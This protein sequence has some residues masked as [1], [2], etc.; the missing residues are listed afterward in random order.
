MPNE[1]QFLDE[2]LLG[3]NDAILVCRLLGQISQ[4]WDDLIDQ[5]RHVP[6]KAINEAFTAAVIRL[7]ALPFYREH[8][9]EL[10]PLLRQCFIDWM[11][12]NQ[13]ERTKSHHDRSMAFVLRDSLVSVVVHCAFL[14]G[15]HEHAIAVAPRIRRFFH[16]ETLETYIGG[17]S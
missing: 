14:V 2:V 6:P 3:R 12:A 11:T 9:G 8:F 17:L 7:P 5:D 13:L 1:E 16:D 15:G 4:T 10:Q